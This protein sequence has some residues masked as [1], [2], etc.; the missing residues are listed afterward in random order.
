MPTDTGNRVKVKNFGSALGM[1][2]SG[3]ML[4][5]QVQGPRF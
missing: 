4:A 1:E 2:L 5:Y 3:R